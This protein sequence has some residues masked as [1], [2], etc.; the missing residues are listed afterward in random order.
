MAGI[1]RG[2]LRYLIGHDGEL[3]GQHG[4]VTEVGYDNENVP[5]MG[6][7]GIG[8]CNLFNEKYDEQSMRT[9]SYYGPY[10]HTSDTAD[11]YGEGQIDPHGAGWVHNLVEQFQRRKAQ[12]FEYIELDNP[13]AY[14]WPDVRDA[15]TRAGAVG[16]KVIAKNPLL[17]DNPL[18]YIDHSNIYGIIVEKDSKNTTEAHVHLRVE[19][20]KPSLPVW[21]VA[22]SRDNGLLWAQARARAIKELGE[23]EMGVTYSPGGEYTRSVDLYVPKP[24]A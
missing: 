22:H 9:R 14:N 23:V 15:I 18:A 5:R 11:E 20:G 17:C 12:G 19:A 4:C 13:D 6:N 3:Q 8:Y 16:L 2:P 7:G 1:L 24:A 10:L 21:F